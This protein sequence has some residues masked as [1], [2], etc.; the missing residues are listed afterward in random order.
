MHLYVLARGIKQETDRWVNDL[1]ARYYPYE[2][3]KGQQKVMCQLAVRP[4]QIYE[5]VFPEDQLDEVLKTIKPQ[6][7]Y[8]G[9]KYKYYQK[10]IDMLGKLMGLKKVPEYVDD[11]KFRIYAPYVAVHPIGIKQDRYDE[12]IEKL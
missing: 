11:K 10:M 4:V 2:I 7:V 6:R 9:G 8:T 12:E 5:I 3:K 1:S